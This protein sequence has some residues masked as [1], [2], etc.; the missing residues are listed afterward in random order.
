MET[1]ALTAGQ[2][3]G[4]CRCLSGIEAGIAAL[5]EEIPELK[6]YTTEKVI[7]FL[8]E[9]RVLQ[10]L[11]TALKDDFQPCASAHESALDAVG[12]EA[13]LQIKEFAGDSRN[14]CMFKIRQGKKVSDYVR[15]MIRKSGPKKAYLAVRNR[16]RQEICVVLAANFTYNDTTYLNWDQLTYS[17]NARVI[18]E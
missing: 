2:K 4:L 6:G 12:E 17:R 1:F 9:V 10:A 8:Q 7:T 11:D 3:E 15:E 14:T 16:H 5:R 18:A 13:T